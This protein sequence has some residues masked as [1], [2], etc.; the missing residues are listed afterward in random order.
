MSTTRLVLRDKLAKQVRTRGVTGIATGGST[1]AIADTGRDEESKYWKG[2]WVTV[3]D[4]SSTATEV[5]ET[6]EVNDF[7]TGVSGGTGQM[8]ILQAFSFTVAT[9]DTYELH[10][11]FSVD[12][13]ND[14][15]NQAIVRAAGKIVTKNSA[16]VTSSTS[17]YAYTLGSTATKVFDVRLQADSS[18]ATAP[19]YKML[20][21]RLRPGASTPT[22]QFNQPIDSG[23]TIRYYY[24]TDPT[25]LAS[26]T[27]TTE[28]N[29]AYIYDA[30]R[31]ELYSI[32]M[33]D[34]KDDK[35]YRRYMTA[36]DDFRRGAERRLR[37]LSTQAPAKR[38]LK[39]TELLGGEAWYEVTFGKSG[40]D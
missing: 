28:L 23:L 7:T 31:A 33:S 39:E 34:A 30:A 18:I 25:E 11:K 1:L 3:T 27:A 38:V 37:Q 19:F 13:L 36:R 22:L 10:Q 35:E 40:L 16:T 4:T 20:K 17:V 14:S 21:W 2:A 32:L 24:T 6:R 15:I 29:T 26:D 9:G 12:E 8:D 5:I